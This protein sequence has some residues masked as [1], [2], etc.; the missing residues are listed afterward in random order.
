MYL[1]IAIFF[2]VTTTALLVV[3]VTSDRPRST[4]F[5]ALAWS[6]VASLA[7]TFAWTAVGGFQPVP[8]AIF[9]VQTF[10][11]GIATLP[12]RNWAADY[13]RRLEQERSKRR[14]RELTARSNKL[15]AEYMAEREA[16][17]D[18]QHVRQQYNKLLDEYRDQ[19]RERANCELGMPTAMRE[20]ANYRAEMGRLYPEVREA[21][22]VL[23]PQIRLL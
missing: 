20:E 1:P 11:Y 22:E 12:L 2:L 23:L 19:E 10:L 3:T 7:S 21:S 6:A 16:N 13:A 4:L 18:E 17:K 8:S 5:R 14:A 15:W 9:T